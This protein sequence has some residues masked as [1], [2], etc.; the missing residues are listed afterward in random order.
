LSSCPERSHRLWTEV[1]S[2]GAF[3]MV[4]FFDDDEDS[5]TYAEQ[6]ERRCPGCGFWLH[7]L[8]TKPSDVAP[9]GG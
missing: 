5:H 8:A 4:V 7:A 3:R 9:Q 6:V 1:G 2:I